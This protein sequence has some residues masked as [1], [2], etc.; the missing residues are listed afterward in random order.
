MLSGNYIA[1]GRANAKQLAMLAAMSLTVIPEGT[2]RD[3]LVAFTHQVIDR[4]H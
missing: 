1:E 4:D 3:E 2:A